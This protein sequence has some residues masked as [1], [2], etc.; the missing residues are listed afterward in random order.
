MSDPT[1]KMLNTSTMHMPNE[2]PDWKRVRH[3]EHEYGFIAFVNGDTT[4]AEEK[5]WVPEWL[6]PLHRLA[7]QHNCILINFDRDGDAIEGIPTYDW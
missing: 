3:C 5:R 4:E 2:D 7:Q 1:S 6:L